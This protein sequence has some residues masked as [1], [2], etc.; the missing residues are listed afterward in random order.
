MLARAFYDDPVFGWFFPAD[1]SRYRRLRRFF[2]TGLHHESLRHGAVEVACVDGRV[3][4]AAA[5]FPSGT[6]FGTEVS[7]LPAICG[8]SAVVSSSSRSISRWR[9]V[10][11]RAKS[12]IGIWQSSGS[13]RSGRDTGSVQ[14]CCARGSGGA[15]RRGCPPTSNPRR[16]KTCRCTSTSASTSP[17]PW[18]CRRVHPLS[19]PC[20]GRIGG[21][22]Q[23]VIEALIDPGEL[24]MI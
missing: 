11:V 23:I 15:M 22:P 4:G 24:G 13:I 6:S 18:A 3:A 8:P 20:G 7:A 14:P 21:E 10:P 2:V 17:A 9:F 5:W 1:G 12:R 16:W 19:A